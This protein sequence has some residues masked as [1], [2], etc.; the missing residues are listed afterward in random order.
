M[1]AHFRTRARREAFGRH[2]SRVDRWGGADFA[3]ASG[4]IPKRQRAQ[5]TPQTQVKG[6]P[7]QIIS[8]AGSA[9]RQMADHATLFSISKAFAWP[10]D[11]SYVENGR[12]RCQCWHGGERPIDLAGGR[13]SDARPSARLGWRRGRQIGP[14]GSEGRVTAASHAISIVRRPW[15]AATGFR[16]ATNKDAL[17][18]RAAGGLAGACRRSS[19]VRYSTERTLSEGAPPAVGGEKKQDRTMAGRRESA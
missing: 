18:L 10:T 4:R 6:G 16:F 8:I 12:R 3:R 2:L 5:I 11:V 17:R 19:R 9:D 15:S 7:I 13:F 1:C 14:G